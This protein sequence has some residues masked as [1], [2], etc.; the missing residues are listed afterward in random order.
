MKKATW[1]GLG[2]AIAIIGGA[3]TAYAANTFTVDYYTIAGTYNGPGSG[4][5]DF[6]TIGCCTSTYFDEVTT[7]LKDGLPV[8][9]TAAT[10]L[11]YT[12]HDVNAAGEITWW[13]PSQNP[14][15]TY[16]GQSTITTPFANYDFYPLE[17]NGSNDSNGFLGAIIRGQFDVTTP[18]Q[19][20]FSFGAD[21]DAFL[22]VDGTVIA[23]E[24]G[25]HG[26]SAA[27][28]STATLSVGLHDITLFYVDRNVTG[29]GL[30]FD[31]TTSDISI[32]PPPSGVPEPASWAIMLLGFGG[33][34][35][36][37]RS[38]RARSSAATA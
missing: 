32:T 9:N 8:Y 7:T 20:S 35:A 31:V 33:L 22:A 37:M 6:N 29:A 18:E 16:E 38:R 28:A 10:D 3:S 23:Q 4:D 25:I 24:G 17:G 5:P 19:V 30:Y 26:V 12:I 27:P 11:P 34:G 13:S 14:Y 36:T 1:L 15:V 21:D 2:A